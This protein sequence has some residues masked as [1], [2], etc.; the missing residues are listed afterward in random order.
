MFAGLESGNC[1][2]VPGDL[3]SESEEETVETEDGRDSPGGRMTKLDSSRATANCFAMLVERV[4]RGGRGCWRLV[5]MWV[6]VL[7]V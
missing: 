7:W 4:G 1:H 6:D 5:S 3:L 2:G